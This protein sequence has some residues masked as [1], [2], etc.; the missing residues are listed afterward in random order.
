MPYL[1]TTQV[2]LRISERVATV[3]TQNRPANGAETADTVSGRPDP[4]PSPRTSSCLPLSSIHERPTNSTHL[5]TPVPA[6]ILADR[7]LTPGRPRSDTDA[8]WGPPVRSIDRL[9][10]GWGVRRSGVPSGG[11]RGGPV[12]SGEGIVRWCGN[13][14]LGGLVMRGAL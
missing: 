2:L 9:V 6:P 14:G 13:E 1:R 11:G 5:S 7:F 10:E 4:P 3:D 12:R 8:V